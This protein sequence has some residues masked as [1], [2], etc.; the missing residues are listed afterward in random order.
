MLHNEI[1][2]FTILGCLKMIC[3]EQEKIL[4]MPPIMKKLLL[5]C[6][7]GTIDSLHTFLFT[8]LALDIHM[9]DIFHALCF[10]KCTLI[11]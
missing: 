8:Y 7:N 2:K 10:V 3:M 11:N 9:I 4:V 5:R 1:E 6:L